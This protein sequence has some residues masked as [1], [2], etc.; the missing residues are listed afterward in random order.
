MTVSELQEIMRTEFP[1][2][3]GKRMYQIW[4]DTIIAIVAMCGVL[5]LAH[6]I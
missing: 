2:R 3:K 6:L 4:I 1:D 5:Y